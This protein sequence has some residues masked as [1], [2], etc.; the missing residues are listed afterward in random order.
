MSPD[1]GVGN[2]MYGTGLH[3]H[4]RQDAELAINRRLF[5]SFNANNK[6][7]HSSNSQESVHS[8]KS[9]KKNER[10]TVLTAVLHP[11]EIKLRNELL[12]RFS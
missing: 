5:T 10:N 2:I 12:K 4:T 1:L 6:A 9:D 11:L 3:I 7:G 8:N